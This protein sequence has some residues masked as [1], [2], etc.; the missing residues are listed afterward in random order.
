MFS[1][2]TL[3]TNA[4][5]TDATG[6]TVNATDFLCQNKVVIKFGL[7]SIAA[8]VKNGF[9]QWIVSA[10]VKLLEMIIDRVCT[11]K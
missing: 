4:T 11:P 8:S 9:A 2:V 7:E 5:I 3:D 10:V 1:N 6:N